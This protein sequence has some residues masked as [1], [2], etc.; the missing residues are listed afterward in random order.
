[1]GKPLATLLLK[2]SRPPAAP[3]G[4]LAGALDSLA[5]T[6]HPNGWIELD[7][8]DTGDPLRALNR[9]C[10]AGQATAILLAQARIA[11]P[12]DAPYA[13]LWDRTEELAAQLVAW[14]TAGAALP[15]LAPGELIRLPV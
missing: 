5:G 9:L 7:D 6:R 11:P 14:K 10:G 1:L 15:T 12:A 8:A 4:A 13:R 3:A 2:M